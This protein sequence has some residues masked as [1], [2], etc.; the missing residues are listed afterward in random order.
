M[1]ETSFFVMVCNHCNSAMFYQTK[2]KTMLLI[3]DTA[4]EA[5]K[6]A[7]TVED[8][9]GKHPLVKEVMLTPKII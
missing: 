9:S 5:R 7:D 8:E 6:Y 1:K 4:E 3:F 2:D